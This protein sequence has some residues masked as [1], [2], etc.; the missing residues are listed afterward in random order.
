[1]EL[2]YDL[3]TNKTRKIK[4]TCNHENNNLLEKFEANY[5]AAYYLSIL[6]EENQPIFNE[7]A[8]RF[9]KSVDK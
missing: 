1:M 2:I 9:E 8:A 7:I 6:F 5:G 4:R 3:Q